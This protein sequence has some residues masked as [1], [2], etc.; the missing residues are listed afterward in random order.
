MPRTTGLTEVEIQERWD[1]VVALTLRGVSAPDIAHQLGITERSVMRIRKN[2][3]VAKPSP[4]RFTAEELA[5]IEKM[6]DDGC[7]I[8]EAARTVGRIPQVVGKRFRGRGWTLAQAS[9]W[10]ALMLETRRRGLLNT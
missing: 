3:M 5:T 1:R 6:L 9:E 8:A 10:G 7:S 4:K 2:R